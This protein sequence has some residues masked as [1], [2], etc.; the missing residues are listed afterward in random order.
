M[1][2]S[3]ASWRAAGSRRESASFFPFLAFA[4]TRN[5]IRTAFFVRVSGRPQQ[6]DP[7][8]VRLSPT[9]PPVLVVRVSRLYERISNRVRAIRRNNFPSCRL[10]DPKPRRVPSPPPDLFVDHKDDTIMSS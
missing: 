3:A 8:T 6:G 2:T 5:I 4:Q 1:G 10:R 9:S 7:F